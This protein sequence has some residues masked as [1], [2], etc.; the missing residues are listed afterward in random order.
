[1]FHRPDGL[2][3]ARTLCILALF[4]VGSLAV[5]TKD[6]EN[7]RFAILG[8]RTGEA[9]PGAYQEAWKETDADYPDFVINVGDTIQGG[10]DETI[11]SEWQQIEKLLSPYRKYRFFYVPGNHDVWSLASAQAFEKYTGRPRHY[12]F[13]YGQAHFTVLDNSRTDSLPFEELVFLKR[14]LEAN[15]KQ[16]LK[17]VFFHRPSWIV[18]VLLRDPAFPLHKL[19]KQYGI[20]YVICGHIHDMLRFELDGVTY[21]SM[22]SSGG[23]LRESRT[24]EHGWFF[25]HT[26]VRVQGDAADF[27]I[28]EL[29]A[30]FGQGRVTKPEDW[31][32]TG[33]KKGAG[34]EKAPVSWINKDYSARNASVGFTDAARRA[35]K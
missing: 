3:W 24:Y 27:E 20:Q 31:S 6:T 28:K 35:G 4:V 29:S 10:N 32:A 21:L 7:F 2:R 15:Q 33:L 34:E 26:L 17:F 8:D 23:H 30:P 25:Q 19:A 22:A 18:K 12:S 13:N 5:Q 14:D 9:F 11:D 16:K 1:M